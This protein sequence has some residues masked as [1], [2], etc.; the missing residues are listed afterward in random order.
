M[1]NH[2]DFSI[3]GLTNLQVLNASHNRIVK[4]DD[5]NFALT[6]LK[7]LNLSDNLL[8]GIF[9]ASV[10]QASGLLSLRLDSNMLT[11]LSASIVELEKVVIDVRHNNICGVQKTEIEQW[12]ASHQTGGEW[13]NTQD[14]FFLPDGVNEWAALDTQTGV[15]AEFSSHHNIS[16]LGLAVQSSEINEIYGYLLGVGEVL[17]AEV[18]T[19]VDADEEDIPPVLIRLVF[20]YNGFD[21]SPENPSLLNIF[22]VDKIAGV[23]MPASCIIDTVNKT[24]ETTVSQ[25][26]L[27]TLLYDYEDQPST[28]GIRTVPSAAKIS[29]RDN[30]GLDLIRKGNKMFA[31][32]SLSQETS[33]SLHLYSVNG[34]LVKSLANGVYGKGL[35]TFDISKN[36]AVLSKQAYIVVLGTNTAKYAKTLIPHLEP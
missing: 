31:N 4:I 13:K 14:C 19:S 30:P 11:G 10:S 26:G 35:H 18:V 32:V 33:I 1:L 28:A 22:Y 27:Y 9:S 25:F 36:S 15:W 7:I 17:S 5:A 3:A 29:G 23:L 12:L 16:G 24:I 6:S 34:R 8:N 20:P 21:F 2:L